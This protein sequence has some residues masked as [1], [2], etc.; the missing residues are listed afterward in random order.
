MHATI[1]LAGLASWTAFI[2]TDAILWGWLAW[3]VLALGIPLGALAA[4]LDS[5]PGWIEQRLGA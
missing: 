5:V 2:F 4:A 3:V 1:M